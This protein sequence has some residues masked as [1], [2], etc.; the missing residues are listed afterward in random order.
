M[1]C[2]HAAMLPKRHLSEL[3]ASFSPFTTARSFKS[4]YV[5]RYYHNLPRS[6]LATIL[7]DSP[8]AAP[9]M[10]KQ[11]QMQRDAEPE[12]AW[13]AWLLLNKMSHASRKIPLRRYGFSS[14]DWRCGG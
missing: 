12:N 7:D 10:K 14:S 4:M 13:F 8:K 3:C 1:K 2:C 11:M 5:T 6:Q 9:K